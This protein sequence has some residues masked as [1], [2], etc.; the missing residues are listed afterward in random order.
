MATS[1][2]LQGQ[3]YFPH[4]TVPNPS[5]DKQSHWYE[6]FL[7]VSDKD[8]N[9]LK[10]SGI[11]D[12]FLFKPGVK[13]YTPDPVVKIATWAHNSDGSPT[14]PPRI[15]D[16]DRQPL[17]DVEIGNGSTVN[18]QWYRREYGGKGQTIVRPQLVAVQILELI[19][20]GTLDRA[21]DALAFA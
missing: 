9:A 19:E 21:D 7:A 4:L 8:F 1:N 16:E 11:S 5:Y 20:R 3:I 6:L 13:N 17:T 15:V 10:D 18:V 14:V 2:V 12:H